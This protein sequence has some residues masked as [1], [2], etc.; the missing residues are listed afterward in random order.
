MSHTEPPTDPRSPDPTSSA[1][2]ASS[3]SPVPPPPRSDGNRAN[4]P[5]AVPGRSEGIGGSPSSPGRHVTPPPPP[6]RATPVPVRRSS[7]S[8]SGRTAVGSAKGIRWRGELETADRVA[9]GGARRE[10]SPEP[11]SDGGDDTGD[12]PAG[13]P[14]AAARDHVTRDAPP[15]L[16]STILHLVLLLVLAL[17]STP[18]GEGISRVMLEIGESERLSSAELTEFA[19]DTS[20]SEN[21]VSDAAEDAPVDIDVPTIFDSVEMLEPVEPMPVETGPGPIQV[22]SAPMFSG[23]SGAMKQALMAMYGGTPETQDAVAMGLAWLKRNQ[24]SQG[25]WSM[26]GP[27]SDG[28]HQENRIAATSMALLA[29]LG[30]GNT[31]FRGEYSEQVDRGLRFLVGRQNRT[32]SFVQGRGWRDDDGYA[33]A[34]ATIAICEAYAMTK[35]SWLREPAQRALDFAM[36]A[37]SSEGGWRYQPRVDSDLSVTGWYMMALQSGISGGLDVDPSVLH[38]VTHFLDS[39]QD[40][41]GAAYR[42]QSRRPVSD[43]MTAEGLLCRQYLGWP[44]DHPPMV[45]GAETL[46][47]D[48][49]FDIAQA[50]VYYW[51]YATQVLHHYGGSAWRDWNAAMRTALPKAQVTRGREA[52]SWAPQGDRWGGNAG[53][54]YTTCLSIYCLEVYYRH[55]PLYSALE[56]ES[57]G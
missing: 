6:P 13:D 16:I 19:I 41:D 14:P 18:V 1:G 15:W 40:Y 52:G 34:Q 4:R 36:E 49:G 23:R 32:G 2:P 38:N 55:L 56:P 17:I 26:R 44:R 9:K 29:F 11:G 39:V 24:E 20:E 47:Q 50:N 53:R 10:E 5:P 8:S 42:Y 33:Q 37:Q 48:Y 25:S 35:D 46:S 45:L 30:D 31:H 57:E 27:Y 51:Y 12:P 22:E 43:T 28:M 7:G 3:G 54:L 21:E